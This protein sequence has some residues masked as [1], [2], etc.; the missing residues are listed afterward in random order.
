MVFCIIA[1]VAFGILGIF[2]AKYR[3]YFK[4]SL[5]CVGRML[6]LRPCNTNFDQEMKNKIVAKLS[7]KSERFAKFVYK[8][9]ALLSWLFLIAFVISL[10][11]T[12]YSVFNLAYYGTCDPIN[13]GSCVF[14]QLE[15]PNQV[16]CPYQNL[17]PKTSVP[18]IGGFDNIVNASVEGKPI[19]YFFG[20]TWCPHCKWERPIFVNATGKF[21]NWTGLQTDD[22]SNAKFESPYM[23]VKTLEVDKQSSPDISIFNHYSPNGT[24]PLIVISG[25]YFR[26]GSGEKLGTDQETQTLTALLC[27]VSNNPIAECNTTEIID[28]TTLIE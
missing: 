4:E 5:H 27:K 26:T 12:A 1:M 22:L 14:N 6:T 21:G 3:T 28:L 18:S 7:T 19:V 13:P 10:A 20:T 17:E 15:N 8:R 2:S 25:K 23:T 11:Y 16:I 9:F 24:I